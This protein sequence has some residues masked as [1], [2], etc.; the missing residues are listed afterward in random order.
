M[1]FAKFTLLELEELLT[2]KLKSGDSVLNLID[3]INCEN[4]I[5]LRKAA[6]RI[7][8]CAAKA[9]QRISGFAITQPG[10]YDDELAMVIAFAFYIVTDDLVTYA[11]EKVKIQRYLYE[12]NRVHP[13]FNKGEFYGDPVIRYQDH[14]KWS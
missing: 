7:L 3:R 10:E 8:K 2:R 13:D 6:N 12:K 4:E 9:Y 1:D 11:H 14:I 5:K